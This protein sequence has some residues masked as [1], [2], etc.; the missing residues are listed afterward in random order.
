VMLNL[1]PPPKPVDPPP[2]AREALQ[3]RLL[4]GITASTAQD[5]E[6]DPDWMVMHIRLIHCDMI[7]VAHLAVRCSAK[8]DR[9]HYAAM[10][11]AG[12]NLLR[13]VLPAMLPLYVE[14][15]DPLECSVW[16]QDDRARESVRHPSFIEAARSAGLPV[17]DSDLAYALVPQDDSEKAVFRELARCA[18]LAM[19]Q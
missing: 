16:L 11:S 18:R 9:A 15:A 3:T 14:F 19:M 10:I 8:G 2:L 6:L 7:R 12:E 5:G 4:A 17:V 13:N 1:I